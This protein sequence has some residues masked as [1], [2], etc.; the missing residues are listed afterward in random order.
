MLGKGGRDFDSKLRQAGAPMGKRFRVFA[1]GAGDKNAVESDKE[2]KK[3]QGA[4]PGFSQCLKRS[5]K[6]VHLTVPVLSKARTSPFCH[7]EAPVGAV[8]I[9]KV[10]RSAATR[11]SH[12]SPEARNDNRLG[13]VLIQS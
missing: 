3:G 11:Q 13:E 6:F 12:A 7:C 9:P 4:L 10:A 8:A 1:Q 5:G 2:R